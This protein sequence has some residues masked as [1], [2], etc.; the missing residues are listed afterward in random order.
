MIFTLLPP[1]CALLTSLN[2]WSTA[3]TP[4]TYDPQLSLPVLNHTRLHSEQLLV[5]LLLQ[6]LLGLLAAALLVR[7]QITLLAA[8]EAA[9]AHLAHECEQTTQWIMRGEPGEEWSTGLA[10]SVKLL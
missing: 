9:A 6:L 4:R 5:S 3:L 10:S 2:S 1:G 8:V 7:Q